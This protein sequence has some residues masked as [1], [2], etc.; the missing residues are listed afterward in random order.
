MYIYIF[1]YNASRCTELER[2][3]RGHV[4][5]SFSW[6][7]GCPKPPKRPPN[8]TALRP[9]QTSDRDTDTRFIDHY[10]RAD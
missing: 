10:K 1:I 7:G 5:E 6:W 2:A 3:G 8:N 9:L 4:I